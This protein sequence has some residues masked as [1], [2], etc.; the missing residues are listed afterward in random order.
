MEILIGCFQA[1][2]ISTRHNL[3]LPQC[4]STW[5]VSLYQLQGQN[6]PSYIHCQSA[7]NSFAAAKRC[8]FFSVLLLY[9]V[10]PYT[11]FCALSNSDHQNFL[12]TKCPELYLSFLTTELSI[13]GLLAK[14]NRMDGWVGD[15]LNK[16]GCLK[17]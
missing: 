6:F 7:S 1:I 14:T 10:V 3:P 4:T 9:P 16:G 17:L 2:L 15:R 13:I 5:I 11:R 12:S 8:S